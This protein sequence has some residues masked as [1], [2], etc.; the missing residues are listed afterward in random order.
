MRRTARVLSATALA[1][2]ALGAFASA[3]FADPAAEGGPRTVAPGAV[4]APVAREETAASAPPP[5]DAGPEGYE[6][7]RAGPYPVAADEG[8]PAPA[9]GPAAPPPVAD[10]N[11]RAVG[12]DAAEAGTASGGADEVGPGD[13]GPDAVGPDAV[14]PEDVGPGVGDLGG[15]GPDAVGPDSVPEGVGP[16]GR[17][18]APDERQPSRDGAARDGATQDS[19]T[20][21]GTASRSPGEDPAVGSRRGVR[22]GEGGAFTDSLPAL[23]AGGVLIAGA[24]GA[25]AYRLRSGGP[26]GRRR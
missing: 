16:E 12:P 8:G 1:S 3:A 5:I 17:S 13:V 6:D 2:A 22:A 23:I 10:V 4:T 18:P 15:V 20:R 21:D 7:R 24:V 19:G 11:P 26:A 9:F 14:R 25:A